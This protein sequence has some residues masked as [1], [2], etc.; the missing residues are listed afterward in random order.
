MGSNYGI[1]E[2]PRNKLPGPPEG[3]PSNG[4]KGE[5]ALKEGLPDVNSLDM[6]EV[7]FDSPYAKILGKFEK[8]LRKG[9]ALTTALLSKYADGV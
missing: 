5:W 3:L 1:Q 6:V 9:R 2:S 8:L 4:I 7:S